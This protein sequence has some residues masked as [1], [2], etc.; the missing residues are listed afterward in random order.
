M[1][2]AQPAP[3]ACAEAMNCNPLKTIEK[4][5]KT[6]GLFGKTLFPAVDFS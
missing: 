6:A 5:R 4:Q 2:P 3:N 1:I